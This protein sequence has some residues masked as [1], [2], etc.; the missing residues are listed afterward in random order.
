MTIRLEVKDDGTITVPAEALG[1]PDPRTI[2]LA[3]SSGAEITLRPAVSPNG[4]PARS[5]WADWHARL[6]SLARAIGEAP[7]TDR[8]AVDMLTEMRR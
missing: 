8:S 7:V 4:E 2:Y 3:R 1:N 6:D 5:E